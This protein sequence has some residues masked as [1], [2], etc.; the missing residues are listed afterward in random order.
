MKRIE[1][2][3]E[4]SR[5]LNKLPKEEL[6]N[7]LSYYDE[8]FLDA[9]VEHEEETS[10]KL[11]NIDDIVR[12]ILADNNIDPDGEPEF[13]VDSTKQDSKNQNNSY[14]QNSQTGN[15]NHSVNNGMSVG[16]KLLIAL[17]TFPIW[18]P[19]IIAIASVVFALIISV[20]AV[21][22]SFALA[23]VACFLYG[24]VSLFTFPV[25]GLISMGIGLIFLS[26]VGLIIS[27]ILKGMFRCVRNILNRIF[28]FFHNL[29][30]RRR[31]Y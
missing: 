23:G 17:I 5:R 3:T 6:E 24:V 4:L 30:Y 12:Q 27:P 9:G 21:S 25:S 10:E 16:A 11:G 20:L 19:L 15:Y 29:L 28:S 22:F 13:Y 7:V 31:A 14:Q 1:F 26:I 18:L 8:I 2:I